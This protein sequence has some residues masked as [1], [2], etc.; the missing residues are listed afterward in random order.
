VELEALRHH[1][2][3]TT[4]A[5]LCEVAALRTQKQQQ[6]QTQQ[7]HQ[8]QVAA[9]P[10]S[11]KELDALRA[12]VDSLHKQLANERKENDVQTHKVIDLTSK[13]RKIEEAH[14]IVVGKVV[15][16]FSIKSALLF[17]LRLNSTV[18]WH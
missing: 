15:L 17:T 4:D 10:S 1:L 7:Q 13:L 16:S 5:W 11:A 8:Q 6:Q 2:A 14:N 3:A 12:Q 18:N 9:V